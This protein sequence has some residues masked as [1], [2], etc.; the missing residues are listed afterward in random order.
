MHATSI[1]GVQ[2]MGAVASLELT[3]GPP[4]PELI[5]AAKTGT[6]RPVPGAGLQ[7]TPALP[8]PGPDDTGPGARPATSFD[9]THLG[10]KGAEFFA[11]QVARALAAVAP[12]LRGKLAP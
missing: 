10:D 11:A 7:T 9:Y 3:P 5:E 1:A 2:A 6:T 12:D 8:R 4:S